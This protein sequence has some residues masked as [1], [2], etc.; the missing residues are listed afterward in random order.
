MTP[1]QDPVA[2]SK[3]RGVAHKTGVTSKS[4]TIKEFFEKGRANLMSALP[5]HINQERFWRV[6]LFAINTNPKLLDCTKDS[7]WMCGLASA[8]LGLEPG[9]LGEV[10]LIPRMNKRKGVMEANFQT[11]YKGD[12]KLMRNT[13]EYDVIDA[14]VIYKND[15][16][17]HED[18]YEPKLVI[19]PAEGDRGPAIKYAAWAKLKDGG[20]ASVV[21][22]KDQVTKFAKAKSQTFNDGPW[23]TDFDAMALK[24]VII[25][26]GKFLPKSIELSDVKI[27]NPEL[28]IDDEAFGMDDIVGE[29]ELVQDDTAGATPPEPT[30]EPT[31]ETRA[32]TS[33]TNMGVPEN[34][35]ADPPA[36]GQPGLGIF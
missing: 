10:W 34:P 33:A 8:Q 32:E 6:L 15:Y 20:R 28:K 12:L 3:E 27:N 23:Q 13:K 30:Q 22:T 25:Q 26:L 19:K 14:K 7:L 18:G 29:S 2:A 11:G 17:E 36:E 1:N 5:K 24:T 35:A 31:T 16:F 21:W 4:V 9:P